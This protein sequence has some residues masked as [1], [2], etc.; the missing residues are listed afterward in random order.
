MGTI[1]QSVGLSLGDS[2]TFAWHDINNVRHEETW[3]IGE[4]DNTRTRPYKTVSCHQLKPFMGQTP[5]HEA[6]VRVPEGSDLKLTMLALHKAAH[7]VA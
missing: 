2:A 3:V 1:L 5:V 6:Y 4:G 7:S